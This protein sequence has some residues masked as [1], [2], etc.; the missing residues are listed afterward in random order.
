METEWLRDEILT[1]LQKIYCLSLD[2]TPAAEILPG[3]AET[4]LEAATHERKWDQG[5]DVPRVRAAFA[6]MCRERRQWPAPRDF[7]DALPEFQ[8]SALGYEAK[9]VTQEQ[10]A[11]NIARLKSMLS[12]KMAAA[13]GD[14]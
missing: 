3:T 2:R 4:W 8:P 9:P 14:A 5:R 13:G 7:M 1:G 10:A 6:T 12:G 11:E